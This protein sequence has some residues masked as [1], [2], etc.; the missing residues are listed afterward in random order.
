MTTVRI[1]QPVRERLAQLEQTHGRLTPNVV[2]NDAKQKKSPLHDLFPWDVEEA[3]QKYWLHRAREIIQ[4]VRLV[5]SNTETVRVDAPFY[6]RDPSLPPAEQGYV[7]VATL[8]RDPQQARESLRLE[9]ARVEGALARARS[10]AVALNLESEIEDLIERVV[11]I[12][13]LAA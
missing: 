8:Q 4:S 3:A 12:R 7:S 11:R 9:F 2:V 13:D 5:S 1:T 10:I 6:V